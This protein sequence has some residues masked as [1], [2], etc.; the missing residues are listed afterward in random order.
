MVRT[1][2]IIINRVKKNLFFIQKGWKLFTETWFWSSVTHICCVLRTSTGA[3]EVLK[4]CMI[5]DGS[6]CS[7]I[8]WLRELWLCCTHEG[9][10]LWIPAQH[11][12]N[13]HTLPSSVMG[14]LFFV[15]QIPVW[16]WVRRQELRHRLLPERKKGLSLWFSSL[17]TWREFRV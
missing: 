7:V 9:R 2:T 5:Y 4:V 13:T 1:T 10:G 11:W 6:C 3:D 15:W 12:N 8:T 16:A 17:K 14:V